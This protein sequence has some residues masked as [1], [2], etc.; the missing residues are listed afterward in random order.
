MR[1]M[2]EVRND[3]RGARYVGLSGHSMGGAVAEVAGALIAAA[4]T[5]T[6]PIVFIDNYGGPAPFRRK[7][8]P[9]IRY[10]LDRIG[11]ANWYV[12]GNDPVPYLMP[13]N[14]HIGHAVHITT[15]TRNP[16]QNHIN[17]Y[18]TLIEEHSA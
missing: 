16:I 7:V 1:L 3:I 8:H 10:G 5:Y 9:V 12:A 6:H 18:R 11:R 4:K 13:W 17:G 14:H 15:G 2:R